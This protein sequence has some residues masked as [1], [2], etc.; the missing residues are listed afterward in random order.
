MFSFCKNF[1]FSQPFQNMEGPQELLQRKY[2]FNVKSVHV[3]T[4]AKEEELG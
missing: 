2:I 1:A 4:I 3:D